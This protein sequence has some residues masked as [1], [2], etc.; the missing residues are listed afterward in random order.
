MI[1][2]KQDARLVEWVNR[3][4][5]LAFDPEK[6][7][8]I[9]TIDDDG[10]L[11]AVVLYSRFSAF[12]CEMTIAS[13]SPRWCSRKFLKAAFQYPF[14]Q[15]GFKRVSFVTTPSNTK[16]IELNKRLG[17][18]LEGVL[19]QWFGDEDGLIFGLLASECIWITSINS[20]RYISRR[21]MAA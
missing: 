13:N 16:A 10:K 18:K 21:L 7:K 6:V 11:L 5:G 12:G 3:Q 15:C 19:R 2:Y 17:A 8:S 14:I 4:L 9:A 1:V 20:S